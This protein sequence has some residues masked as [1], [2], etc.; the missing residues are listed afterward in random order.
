MDAIPQW[1]CK[2]G[3]VKRKIIHGIHPLGPDL[4]IS[5]GGDAAG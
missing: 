3:A 4:A 1:Q 5:S 2:I